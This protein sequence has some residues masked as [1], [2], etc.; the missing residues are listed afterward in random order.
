[1][2]GPQ[3][4]INP[5]SKKESVSNDI[6]A[7]IVFD[8]ISGEMLVNRQYRTVKALRANR[9][10]CLVCRYNF[11][12]D[13]FM[14]KE[15][16]EE[17]FATNKP[18]DHKPLIDSITG[19]KDWLALSTTFAVR[20]D[21]PSNI[22]FGYILAYAGVGLKDVLQYSHG[23]AVKVGPFEKR[24]NAGVQDDFLNLSDD[25]AVKYGYN[26]CRCPEGSGKAPVPTGEQMRR[27]MLA[28]QKEM[29][30]ISA[31]CTIG[32]NCDPFR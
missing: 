32:E 10:P 30:T 5:R 28:N 7:R 15:L 26:L 22:H 20:M 29:G 27:D 3:V 1:M 9:Y 25:F 16:G 12:A 19:T 18:W 14:L 24:F 2:P 4:Q 8:V 23:I 21:V 17:K 11:Y 31:G 6:D 13:V